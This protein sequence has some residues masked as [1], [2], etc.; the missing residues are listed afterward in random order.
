MADSLIQLTYDGGD[1]KNYAIDMRL[2]GISLQGIDRIISEGL[3][4]LSTGRLAKRGERA[5]V[6]TKIQEPIPGS[7][8]LIGYWQEVSTSLAIGVPIVQTIGTDI[9]SHY[10]K[11]VLSHYSGK[12][13]ES[14]AAMEAV[15]RIAQS[16]IAASDRTD[17]RRHQEAMGM[18][19]LLA[20]SMERLGPA[21][22][23]Y[24]APVGRSVDSAAFFAGDN[25]PTRIGVEDAEA[26]RET[27]EIDWWPVAEL[28]LRTDGFKFHTHGLSVENPERDGYLMAKVSDPTFEKEENAYTE[29]AQRKSRIIVLA[30]KGY[31]NGLLQ[32]LDIV[33]YV[34]EIE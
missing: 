32:Q 29:A 21:A 20:M 14:E 11:G 4:V 10:V 13:S 22:N 26:I 2:L 8:N 9:I 12:Q 16:A 27:N 3:I 19:Q 15:E 23:Q 7:Y 25:P 5:T 6:I 33:D 17:Q 24:A 18:Q 1:A 30:R 31:R 28:E 34:R